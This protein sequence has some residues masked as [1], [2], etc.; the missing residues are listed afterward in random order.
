MM[1]KILVVGAGKSTSYLIDYFLEKSTAENLH[2]TIGD[3]NPDG[4]ASE[5]R[6]HTN[7]TIIKLDVFND[8][9]RKAAVEE[10]DIVVSMLPARMHMKVAEDCISIE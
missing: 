4:I 5:I 2:L 10:S 3:I 9:D 6:N 7:C 8:N 1:R